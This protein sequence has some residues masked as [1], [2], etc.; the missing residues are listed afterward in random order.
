MQRFQ[1]LAS[2]W[3]VNLLILVPFFSY[4]GWREKGLLFSYWQLFYAA[5]FAVA[6]GF[7][8]AAVVVYLRAAGGVLPA[9]SGTLADAASRT[10]DLDSQLRAAAQM[11]QSLMGI[12]PLREAATILMLA[13][14]AL[15]VGRTRRERWA[16]FL[17]VF[18]LWDIVYYAGL[19][20]TVRWP[21]SLTSS[22]VLFLVPVPWIA[23]VWYPVLVSALA[24]VAVLLARRNAPVLPPNDPASQA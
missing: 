14:V 10:P 15:L 7:V 16:A 21:E 17:W 13:A 11:P 22:D 18:A 19:R 23:Q 1:L 2:P 6:F 24:L 12:E 5:V 4:F 8:E 9:Y 3:W 20:A